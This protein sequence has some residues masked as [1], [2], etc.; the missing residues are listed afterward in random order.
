MAMFG[1]KKHGAFHAP[2]C[3]IA[4]HQINYPGGTV[5]EKRPNT[6]HSHF[7][8]RCANLKPFACVSNGQQPDDTSV[9][10]H[11]L[12]SRIVCLAVATAVTTLTLGFSGC[13]FSGS[14]GNSYIDRFMEK[15]VGCMRDHVWAKRAFHLRYGHCERI[16][17]DHFH[18]G[19]LAGYGNVCQGH[20][21]ECPPLPPEKY[22]SYNYRNEDGS[23]MQDAWFAGFEAGASS[24]KADGAAKFQ[25]IKI[26]RDL[27]EAM[28]QAEAIEHMHSGFETEHIVEGSVVTLPESTIPTNSRLVPQSNNPSQMNTSYGLPSTGINQQS[29]PLAQP[30]LPINGSPLPIPMNRPITNTPTSSGMPLPSK[31][32]PAQVPIVTG[33]KR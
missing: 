33:N 13:C 28:L 3:L 9:Q 2:A 4:S 30:P 16:H 23:Q 25:E 12:M 6:L 10:G 32:V 1:V 7:L 18:E 11:R 5:A 27:Q 29:T 14:G 31:I 22:W 26:S 15:Q 19:F 17:A 8:N 24:A 21:G 20:G